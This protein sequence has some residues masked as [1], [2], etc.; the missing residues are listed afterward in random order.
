MT[1]RVEEISQIYARKTGIERTPD[2]LTLKLNEEVGELT[3]AFLA[4]TGRARDRGR[5]DAEIREVLADELADVVA[6]ALLVGRALDLDLETALDRKW[7]AW[8]GAAS[9]RSA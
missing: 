3:Q 9:E 2:W 7:F 8:L 1:A 4:V 6:H 5:S